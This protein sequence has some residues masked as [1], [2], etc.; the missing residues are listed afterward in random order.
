MPE[1][2]D[3][4]IVIES[5]HRVPPRPPRSVAHW[6]AEAARHGGVGSIRQSLSAAAQLDS[7]YRESAIASDVSGATSDN[8][9][10]HRPP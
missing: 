4:P 9:S 1:C 6:Q 10:L 7:S 3:R 8:G 2:T 5:P